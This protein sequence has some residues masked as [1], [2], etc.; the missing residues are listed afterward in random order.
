MSSTRETLNTPKKKSFYFNGLEQNEKCF[1]FG[2]GFILFSTFY[3]FYNSYVNK[4]KVSKNSIFAKINEN[5]SKYSVY[6]MEY[7][8]SY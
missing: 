4:I 1:D 2:K 7:K 8:G 6:M 5:W 3:F